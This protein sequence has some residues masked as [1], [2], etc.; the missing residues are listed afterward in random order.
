MTN[1][2]IYDKDVDHLT[3]YK[4]KG[5]IDSSV[6]MGLVVLGLSKKKELVGIEYMGINKNFKIP[7]DVLNTM[8]RFYM[9]LIKRH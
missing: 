6:D 1:T 3:I 4:E 8:L 9:T 7:L 5:K 2:I